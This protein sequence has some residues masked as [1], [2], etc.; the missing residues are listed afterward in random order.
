[1]ELRFE[2]YPWRPFRIPRRTWRPR[3]AAPGWVALQRKLSYERTLPLPAVPWRAS[4][5]RSP[6]GP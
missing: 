1:M 2:A 6:P 5:R 3:P 4:F